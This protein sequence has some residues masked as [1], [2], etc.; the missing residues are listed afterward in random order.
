MKEKSFCNHGNNKFALNLPN[1]IR[2]ST[3]FG[4]GSYCENHNWKN[5]ESTLEN[6]YIKQ[7][8]RIEEGSNDVEIMVSCPDNKWLERLQKKYDFEGSVKGH[9]KMPEWLEILGKCK[10]FKPKNK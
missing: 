6:K 3:T 9:I 10:N 8:E 7:F 1:G 4:W 2:I 5:P